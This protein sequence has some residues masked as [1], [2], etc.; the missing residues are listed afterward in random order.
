MKN[1]WIPTREGENKKKEE[2]RERKNEGEEERERFDG[3][4]KSA[5]TH[6]PRR[7]TRYFKMTHGSETRTPGFC[8]LV[9][10]RFTR[11]SRRAPLEYTYFF[12][13]FLSRGSTRMRL[14]RYVGRV[15]P[16]DV[17]LAS[18]FA[19][20]QN[21]EELTEWTIL[22][23]LLLHSSF[24][25]LSFAH[26]YDTFTPGRRKGYAE[27]FSIHVLRPEGRVPEE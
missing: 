12:F 5:L 16:R 7:C 18:V 14:Q 21:G 4:H 27:E 1:K 9:H 20:T 26:T 17:V 11:T 2:I 6:A 25:P 22:L 23:L 3:A 15:L 19:S 10:V 24:F 13:S 8:S